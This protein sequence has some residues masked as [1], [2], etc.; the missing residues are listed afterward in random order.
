[1]LEIQLFKMQLS[2][3]YKELASKEDLIIQPQIITNNK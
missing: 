3:M 1:M 2:K